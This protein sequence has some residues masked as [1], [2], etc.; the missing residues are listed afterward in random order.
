MG[1]REFNG[2]STLHYWINVSGVEGRNLNYLW[3]FVNVPS[4]WNSIENFN[5]ST[6]SIHN[7]SVVSTSFRVKKL[8]EYTLKFTLKNDNGEILKEKINN[9]TI[10]N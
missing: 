4:A 9:F 1:A 8:W 7:D 6:G 5:T 10:N 3:E 2:Y